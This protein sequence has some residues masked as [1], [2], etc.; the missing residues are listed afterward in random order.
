MKRFLSF[1]LFTFATA[2]MCF[3]I[4]RWGFQ[5]DVGDAIGAGMGAAL[6]GLVVELIRRRN[7][8]D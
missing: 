5:S 2:F 3:A 4:M 1:L 7:N 8:A 6:G